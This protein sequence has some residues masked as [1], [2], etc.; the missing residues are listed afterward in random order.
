M[1]NK[2]ISLILSAVMLISVFPAVPAF[3]SD[4]WDGTSKTEPTVENGVYQIGNGAELA[5]FS[6]ETK[7]KSELCAVLT[8]DIDLGGKEWSPIGMP[9]SGYV[10]EAYAGTFDGQNHTV[11]G[12]C[13]N[14]SSAFYGLFYC[15]YGG[16][17]KNVNVSGDVATTGNTAGGIVGKL[18]GG[19]IENCSF[20]GSVKAKGNYAG[21]IVANI[22]T[23][24][25]SASTVTACSNSGDISGKYAG[26]ILG[27][28]TA[29]ANINNCY[30]TG[31][32]S[33]STRSAGI[34]G[35]Q[36]AGTINYCYNIG[37]SASGIFGFSNA[38]V[39]NCYYLNDE[40]VTPGGT[41]S[42]C[43]KITDKTA[44][45]ENLNSGESK[46]FVDDTK[47]KNEGYPI[48]FWQNRL[49]PEEEAAE[50]KRKED[51][52]KVKKALEEL[53]LDTKPVKENCRLNLP[54][55][56]GECSIEWASSNADVI[57]N[58]G[59]VTL[60][61]KNIVN[62]TMTA[63]VICG[64]ISD[65]KDFTISV[66]SENMD[67]DVYLQTVLDEMEWNFKQL[68]P[69]YSQDSNII[70]KFQNLLKS[71]GF[72]G[73]TVT[74]NSTSDESL[75]SSN[76][77]ITYPALDENSFANGRQVKISFNLTVGSTTVAYPASDANA[78]LV[79]WDTGSVRNNLENKA[80]DLLKD[81]DL[82]AV[83][84]NLSLPSNTGRNEGKYSFAWIEWKSS[85]ETHLAVS[86]E[87]RNGSAD[88]LY[89][90]YV[91]N[92]YQDNREH[93]VTLT[94]T[95]TNPS[96]DVSV[97]KEFEVTVSPLSQDEFEH[98]LHIMNKIL[99]CYT[100]DKLTDFATGHPVDITAV[101]GD[102]QLVIPK[103]VVKA[104]ELAELNYGEY[105]DYWN[106]KFTVESS[107][108][109]V[110]E[111]NSF[112]ADVYRPLGEDSSADKT[113][114]L[115]V[116]M[117]SR[118]NPNLVSVKN[119]P[120]TVKHLSRQELNDAMSLM[121][122]AKTSYADGLLGNNSDVY[123]IIDNLTPYQEITWNSD[124]TNVEFVYTHSD[125][126]GNGI[127]VDTLEN[128]E[129][130][131]DWRLFRSSNKDLISNET[132]IIN[133]TP[134]E[135][136]FV[137]INSVLTD[138]TFGKYYT[139]FQNDSSYDAETLAKFR[140]LYK[141]PVSAYVM[142]IGNGNYDE[143]YAV[144]PTE[145]K[146]AMFSARLFSFK[147]ELD[148]PISVTFTL[149]GLDGKT[150]ISKVSE[151]SF[152]KGATVFDVFKKVLSDNNINY[153]AKGSYVSSI[154]GLAE[155]DYGSASGWMYTVG[156]VFVNS[157]M[158]AQELA[159]GEDIVVMYVTDY[160]KANLPADSTDNNGSQN[161]GKPSDNT[162]NQNDSNQQDSSLNADSGAGNNN[163][164]EIKNKVTNNAS[165]ND[166]QKNNNGKTV[167]SIAESKTAVSSN[168]SKT[169]SADSE[170]SA[171]ENVTPDS[172][173]DT[174]SSAG[175]IALPDSEKA[176]TPANDT[177]SK[178]E[179]ND[180]QK[181]IIIGSL[182]GTLLLLLIVI[183]ILRKKKN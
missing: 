101:D 179:K 176:E 54:L 68:Q 174:A 29:K 24:S 145:Q 15:I 20:S 118:K 169:V 43:E 137:K 160:T 136:T 6:E 23:N 85:D 75:I 173:E 77:K 146:A 11:S 34:S 35:Q 135:D 31:N 39:T 155:K 4:A 181:L 154:N 57:S 161:T 52:E 105:W 107:D 16:T 44:L 18:Q 41:A 59:V 130:Q 139:K 97:I 121:D 168:V 163:T 142:V 76:G 162:N 12:L 95:I 124:K 144:T 67:E 71:K 126:K 141:Q 120:V 156:N 115:T 55:Q 159:G 46:L 19:T 138:E 66:W 127:I 82:S 104:D 3:A 117:A 61:D 147:N 69:V 30:N 175:G 81:Y 47:N 49:T 62:V 72:D 110:I 143:I 183:L 32:I 63:K 171:E 140:Q 86:G 149:L 51:T 96:T 65:T 113:V 158:N 27:Y 132:L 88:A 79:P 91:G 125:I 90:P 128:W 1:K 170:S 53:S 122:T 102:I 108:T 84:S 182:I 9:A 180:N 8:D 177:A 109:D 134:A 36:T 21:G 28:T 58:E 167:K 38:A 13:I 151:K 73:I 152:T 114:I 60:P 70:V 45:L 33:G 148:K 100:A 14:T 98:S 5:W 37:S 93:T 129:E 99:E 87:N 83:T 48:L 172:A 133:E 112:K 42:S 164:V 80:D 165:T 40:T 78:L 26:G 2:I 50:Q 106:Y 89:N 178:S 22:V 153:V 25:K 119:I 166:K 74:M 157:C 64:E 111:V 123:S 116:K 92:V 17:V 103:N 7:T 150:L 10:S 56:I 94:A 131:E